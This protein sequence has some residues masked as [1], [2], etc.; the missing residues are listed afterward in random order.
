MAT[1]GNTPVSALNTKAN[2]LTELSGRRWVSRFQ[3]STA[4]RDLAMPFRRGAEAFIAALRAAGA[5]VTIAATLRDPERAY[6]MHW[7][8]R[9]VKKNAD[10]QKIP[11]MKG[12]NIRWAHEGADG[13]H[14]KAKS[15]EAALE[16]VRGFNIQNLGTEPSLKS[17]HTSGCAI[18]MT[19]RWDGSLSIQD[20]REKTIEIASM[21]RDGTNLKLRQV[22]ESYG[23]IKYN[24]SGRDDPHWS[25]R[26]A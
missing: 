17:R 12:V 23:V 19:I 15:I 9:L 13:K 18:D 8:W 6:L 3:G 26:G 22:G 20:A 7:S 11:P 4:T 21:P 10:P 25:D 24:R 14:S 16:M 2:P 1:L 5:R